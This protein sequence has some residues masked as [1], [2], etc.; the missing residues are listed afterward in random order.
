VITFP[1]D[2]PAYGSKIILWNNP[3]SIQNPPTCSLN[4]TPG[5]NIPNGGSVNF[6][7]NIT[8]SLSNIFSEPNG[9]G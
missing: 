9:T 5:G 6:S 2:V 4:A 1:T 8:N 7:W 3:S